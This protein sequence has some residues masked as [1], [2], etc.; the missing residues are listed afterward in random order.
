MIGKRTIKKRMRNA[1]ILVVIVFGVIIGRIAFLQFVQGEELSKRAYEQQTSDRNVSPKRGT[2]YDATGKNILAVSSSVETVT[3]N[4]GN[5]KDK[6]KV[7]KKLAELFETDYEEML[8][9][10]SK[11]TSIVNIAK[12]VE[13]DKTNNLREWMQENN[14]TEGINIDEDTKRFYPYNNLA[15]QIIGFC[16][17]DNQGLNGIEAKYED[18]LKGTKGSI[19][20]VTDARGR[21]I[22]NENESY[23]KPIDGSDLVLTIDATIQGI[24]EKYLK[25]ACIDNDCKDGGNVVIMNPQNGDILAIA[26]YPDY[27]LNSPF[28]VNESLSKEEQSKQ[29]QTL[30]RNKAI[31][32]PISPY[33]FTLILLHQIFF[34]YITYLYSVTSLLYKG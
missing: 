13:K 14:V 20:K 25:Q 22:E 7:A 33:F 18:I 23:N 3:V 29:M 6:E 26:G 4:P 28:E 12:K 2:I 17:S 27:N 16:G 32:L 11:R 34:A 1:L 5:I 10:I 19:S 8:K 30:W 15:S 9:K 31:I 21:K 24:A